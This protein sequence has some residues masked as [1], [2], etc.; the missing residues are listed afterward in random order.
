MS[1]LL[2]L[3]SFMFLISTLIS[4]LKEDFLSS[5][6]LCVGTR[7]SSGPWEKELHVSHEFINNLTKLSAYLGKRNCFS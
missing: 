3:E 1:T 5:A 2:V 6:K 4:G 7:E